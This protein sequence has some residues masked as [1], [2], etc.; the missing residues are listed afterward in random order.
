MYNSSRVCSLSV[1]VALVWRTVGNPFAFFSFNDAT[2]R[3]FGD[4]PTVD[5]CISRNLATREGTGGVKLGESVFVV[6]KKSW[7]LAEDLEIRCL[8][9]DAKPLFTS[10]RSTPVIFD[11]HSGA[12]VP[13]PTS[14]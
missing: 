9:T 12:F 11:H 1:H 7:D 14:I 13:T 5:S 10:I 6:V 2:S 3:N 4:I 8:Q